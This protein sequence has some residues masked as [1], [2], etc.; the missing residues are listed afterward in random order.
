MLVL[1]VPSCTRQTRQ[2]CVACHVGSF[3]P[4]LTPFGR[5]FKCNGYTMKVGNDMEIPLSRMLVESFEHTKKAQDRA[6]MPSGFRTNNNGSL[7][8]A[9]LFLAGRL[10]DHKRMCMPG[11]GQRLLARGVGMIDIG[12]CQ[13]TLTECQL[14]LGQCELR[15]L[16]DRR[17]TVGCTG[18]RHTRA[19]HI[20]VLELD[21]QRAI[22]VMAQPR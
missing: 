9:S 15:I 12:V 14:G 8:R 1:A 17:L 22:A 4:E 19:Q 6:D 18:V 16:I 21:E 2:L 10:S 3:G 13:A 7:D 11:M 20:A 5:E